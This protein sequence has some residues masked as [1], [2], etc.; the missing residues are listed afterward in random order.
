MTTVVVTTTSGS[1]DG[2]CT[3]GG[4]NTQ[5]VND[6]QYAAGNRVYFRFVNVAV[7]QGS[8][9]DSAT[10]AVQVH[11]AKSNTY[12]LESFDV[13][14]RFEDVD[15]SAAIGSSEDVTA[16]ATTTASTT[17]DYVATANNE[18]ETN[19]VAAPL[20][21]VI[22]RAGWASGNAAALFA[23]PTSIGARRYN[24]WSY[25]GAATNSAILTIDYSA[26]GGGATVTGVVTGALPALTADAAGAGTS[27][28]PVAAQLPALTGNL[29]GQVDAVTAAIDGALPALAGDLAGQA[30]TGGPVAGALPALTADL[31]AASTSG[32]ALAGV[33]PALTGELTAAVPAVGQIAATLPALAASFTGT[34]AVPDNVPARSAAAVSGLRSSAAT[35]TARRSSSAAVTARRTS[36]STVSGG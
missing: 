3:S 7:P 27:A 26:G 28:G 2:H 10:I 1:D 36:T 22:S 32:G 35:V 29:A 6:L 25:E 33:L 11:D 31:A 20:Q 4:T 18:W 17:A 12:P 8:T 24:A 30:S 14:H 9:I 13:V 21:E 19:D 16:R 15:D 34:A 5:G 23:T